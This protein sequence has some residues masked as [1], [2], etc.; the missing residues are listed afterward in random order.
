MTDA[1]HGAAKVPGARPP[2]QPRETTPAGPILSVEDLRVRFGPTHAVSGVSFQLRPGEFYGIVGESGSGKSVTARAIVNLLSASATVSGAIRFRGEDVL[3]ASEARLQ[4]LRGAEIGFVFQDAI[5]ALDPV[6]TVGSQ[7]VEALRAGPQRLGR[8]ASVARAGALLA[9]VGIA[10]PGRCMASYPHQLSGGMRQRVVI[11]AALISGPSLV[12]ADEPT[13]ALDVTVQRQV[14]DLLRGIA[15][16]RGLAVILIT[17][18]LGV[19][20]QVCHRV[21]VFY[22]GLMVEE[23]DTRSLFRNP[24]HPYTAALIESLPQLGRRVPF[25]AIPGVPPQIR[26]PLAA[27]PF[28][29]RCSRVLPV[30]T[31]RVPEETLA[32]DRR[33]R[34]ANP[35]P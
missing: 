26:A 16:A 17:H 7:L 11:A 5:A 22:G 34:C 25:R 9:E 33:H 10:D 19:I 20:A 18:D 23:A 6:Y 24:R 35:R 21:A 30:C 8:A 31:A 32:G 12:I 14:L 1:F 4:Q 27:C 15:T 13:T 28:A 2:G 29:P 3:A